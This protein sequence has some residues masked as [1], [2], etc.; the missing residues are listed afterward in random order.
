MLC[1][2]LGLVV[3]ELCDSLCRWRLCELDDLFLG[4]CWAL[5]SVDL[6]VM[7]CVFFFVLS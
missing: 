4:L 1:V 5:F 6:C 2:V 3:R 7:V